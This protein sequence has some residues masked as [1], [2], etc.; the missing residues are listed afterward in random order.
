MDLAAVLVAKL[1]ETE[2]EGAD[3]WHDCGY[4]SEMNIKWE[5][6][7]TAIREALNDLTTVSEFN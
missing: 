2:F 7:E 6:M 3:G 4:C 5:R 1:Q